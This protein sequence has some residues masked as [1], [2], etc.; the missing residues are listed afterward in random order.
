MGMGISIGHLLLTLL[1]VVLVFGTKK[2]RNIGSDLGG[3]IKS[4]RQAM[5]DG[6]IEREGNYTQSTSQPTVILA[7]V[8]P[9]DKNE[10]IEGQVTEK[11]IKSN[12]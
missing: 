10:V 8:V 2:L 5:Q 9:A 1:V 3:A 6:E 4:F 11:Q 7:K 12:G